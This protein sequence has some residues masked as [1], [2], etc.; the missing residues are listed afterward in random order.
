M[1]LDTTNLSL[2]PPAPFDFANTAYSHGWVVLAPN[3]WDKEHHVMRRLHRLG[4]GKIVLL[5]ITGTGTVRKPGIHIAVQHTGKLGVKAQS[6]I[7]AAV[8]HMFRLNE[9][10]T[11]FYRLCRKRGK[12]WAP[13]TKGLGRLL[14]SPTV[15][16]D[17]IKSICT[18]NIQWSGTKRMVEG[19]VQTLGEPFPGD[20]GLRAFPTSE[21]LAAAPAKTFTETVRLG[22]RGPFIHE[23]AQQSATGKVDFEVLG[24]PDLSTP[25]LKKRLLALKGVGPYAAATLLML[26][27]RYDE[28]AVDTVYRDFVGKKYFNGKCPPD[29]KACTFYDDWGSWKYLAYWFDVWRGLEEKV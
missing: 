19:L 2:Q 18:T 21:T 25:E 13:I 4:S 27:G 24:N 5:E 22:Y 20:E 14:R 29:R 12:H 8:S 1:K 3:Q 17:V 16:E 11:E 28:V 26:L 10:L 9:D 6:E 15:F 23:L 7:I